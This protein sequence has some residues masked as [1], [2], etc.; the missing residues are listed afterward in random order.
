MIEIEDKR[1]YKI[2]QINCKVRKLSTLS[3]TRK[4]NN[5]RI[6]KKVARFIL[7]TSLCNQFLFEFA[8]FDF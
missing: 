7:S 5:L 6:N 8:L 3:E 2:I 4:S 1:I